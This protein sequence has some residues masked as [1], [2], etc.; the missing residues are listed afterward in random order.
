MD[1]QVPAPGG[2]GPGNPAAL[3]AR[4]PDPA[5]DIP[6]NPAHFFRRIGDLPLSPVPGALAPVPSLLPLSFVGGILGPAV[7]TNG[8]AAVRGF[9]PLQRGV[10]PT[11]YEAVVTQLEAEPQG[12]GLDPTAQYVSVPHAAAAVL[13]AVERIVALGAPLHP[14]YVIGLGDLYDYEPMAPGAP[15]AFIALS[16]APSGLT[17]S[18]LEGPGTFLVHLGF[19]S[20]LCFGICLS[21]SR[22]QPATPTRR[23]LMAVQP[24]AAAAGVAP[25]AVGA[26]I[27]AHDLREWLNLTQPA[28][29]VALIRSF[30]PALQA[31]E[32]NLRDRHHLRFGTVDQKE[33]LVAALATEQPLRAR[34]PNLAR[35]FGLAITSV[36]AVTVL[37]R[38][39]RVAS[40]STSATVVDL[41]ALFRLESMIKESVRSLSSAGAIVAT[42]SDRVSRVEEALTGTQ[43]A[44]GGSASGASSSSSSVYSNDLTTALDNASWRATEA[45]ILAELSQIPPNKL[46]VFELITQSSVLGARQ[47]ALSDKKTA[48]QN[49][50]LSLSDPLRRALDLLSGKGVRHEIVATSLVADLTTRLPSTNEEILFHQVLPFEI[51]GQILRG[52]F[53]EVPW[54]KLLR[55][56]LQVEK[57]GCEIADYPKGLFDPLVPPLLQPRL[58]RLSALLGLP[59]IHVAGTIPVPAAQPANFATLSTIVTNI[60]KGYSAVHGVASPFTDGNHAMLVKFHDASFAEAAQV[61]HRFYGN[62]NPA[63]PVPVSLFNPVSSPA[64]AALSRLSQAMAS[65]SKTAAEQ[66][67]LNGVLAEV[68]AHGGSLASFISSLRSRPPS[69]SSQ[70]AGSPHAASSKAKLEAISPRAA[71]LGARSRSSSPSAREPVGAV[72]SRFHEAVREGA[73]GETFWYIDD[74]GGR[75]SDIYWYAPLEKL[76]GKS[77]HELDFPVILSKRSSAVA[78]ATLSSMPGEKGHTHATDTAFVAPFPDF[79]DQANRLF[80]EPADASGSAVGLIK[81]ER[82]RSRSRSRSRSAERGQRPKSSEADLASRAERGRSPAPKREDGQRPKH[83]QGRKPSKSKSRSRSRSPIQFDDKPAGKDGKGATRHEPAKPDAT[84]GKSNVKGAPSNMAKLFVAGS[85]LVPKADAAATSAVSSWGSLAYTSFAVLFGHARAM[86]MTIAGA[87]RPVLLLG[88]RAPTAV[89]RTFLVIV[90]AIPDQPVRLLA[91]LMANALIG[92]ES[93]EAES[94]DAALT[95]AK[96]LLSVLPLSPFAEEPMLFPSFEIIPTTADEHSTVD[97]IVV[98][99]IHSQRDLPEFTLDG[100]TWLTWMALA[101]ATSA[102]FALV[103]HAVNRAKTFR[104]TISREVFE[105]LLSASTTFRSGARELR[106]APVASEDP[107]PSDAGKTFEQLLG[108]SLAADE[109]LRRTLLSIPDSDPLASQLHAYADRI[110]PADVSEIPPAFK[111]PGVLPTFDSA[112][113]F[114]TPFT[115]RVQPPTTTPLP[116]VLPQ[117]K[118]PANFNP[119]SLRDLLTDEAQRS[120]ERFYGS[121]YDWLLLVD[122]LSVLLERNR[123]AFRAILTQT[124]QQATTRHL[125]R[126]LGQDADAHTKSALALA[127]ALISGSPANARDAWPSLSRAEALHMVRQA[128]V[129][130]YDGPSDDDILARLLAERPQVLAL[131]QSA[132]VPAAR[133]IV[134]DLRGQVPVPLDFTRQITTHLNLDFVRECKRLH[135][136]YPDKELWD[137]LLHGVRFKCGQLTQIVLQPHLSSLPLGFVNVHKELKRLVGKGFFECFENPPFCPWQTLPMGVAFRKLEPDRPRRTTDGGSPRR[138]HRAALITT[139]DGVRYRRDGDSDWLVDSD[140]ARVVPLNV[141]TRWP[142]D[143]I[144]RGT[145]DTFF[146]GWLTRLHSRS[147]SPPPFHPLLQHADGRPLTPPPS[148]PA[149]PRPARKLR[150]FLH[151]FSGEPSEEFTISSYLAALHWEAED[152]D[153]LHDKVEFDVTREES[154]NALLAKV[155]AGKYFIVW[156]GPPCNPYSVADDERPQ[157][158]SVKKPWGVEPCPSE[159]QNYVT[160]ANTVTRFVGRMIVACDESDTHW[161]VENPSPHD[162]PG[163][164]GF[165]EE[166]ADYGTIWHALDSLDDLRL[167]RFFE[168]T[169]PYCAMGMLYQKPTRLRSSL[170]LLILAFSGLVCVHR[171]HAKRLRG[172]VNGVSVTKSAQAYPP[173]MIERAGDAIEAAFVEATSDSAGASALVS[174]SSAALGAGAASQLTVSSIPSPP[175]LRLGTV[176]DVDITRGGPTPHF[177]NPFKMGE[178]GTNRHLREIAV[179]TYRAWLDARVVKAKNWPTSLPVS[180]RLSELTGEIV[181]RHLEG[182]FHRHGRLVRFH[183]VCGARCYGKSC[184]GHAL[185]ALAAQ[186]LDGSSDPPF[187]KE[188]KSTVPEAMSDLAVLLHLSYLTGLPVYQIC[189]DVSDFF[190]QHRLHPSEQPKVGLVTLELDLLVARAGQLRK[191]VPRLCNVAESV[192]GYGLFPA[193][194]VCQRHAY[195]LT[196]LWLVEM[197]MRSRPIVAALCMRFPVLARWRDERQRHLE[198]PPSE[199]DPTERVRLAQTCFWAMS[200][201]SDDSHQKILGC[202]LTV[203]GLRVWIEITSKLNLT[204]AIV[205]KQM[206]GQNVLNQGLRFH[207][208]LGITYVPADKLRRCF[209]SIRLTARGLATLREY[210]SLLGLLQSLLF[211]VGLRRSAMFGLWAPF[212]VSVFSPE[213]PLVPTPLILEK[214]KLWQTRLCEC[215]G[216]SFESGIDKALDS[217]RRATIPPNAKV[218]YVL[219]SDASKMGAVLPGVGGCLGGDGWRYPDD[220]G[221]SEAEL[222]LPIAVTEFAA[223]YGEVESYGDEIPEDACVMAEVDALATVDAV[224]DETAHKELMQLVFSELQE[225][226]QWH[227]IRER[228]VIAHCQGYVNVMADAWSR[229]ELHVAQQLCR[230][231]G[232]AFSQ[233]PSP[234]RLRI[235]MGL[236]LATHAQAKMPI[237][238][239][240][241]DIRFTDGDGPFP[242]VLAQPDFYN[243]AFVAH[244]VDRPC[245]PSPQWS[246]SLFQPAY[247]VLEQLDHQYLGLDF[248]LSTGADVA[249]PSTPPKAPLLQQPAE[250]ASVERAPELTPEA[251]RQRKSGPHPQHLAS[252]VAALLEADTSPLAL[253]P[254]SFTLLS[255]CER[256]YDPR[257]ATAPRTAKGQVS[258]WKHWEAWCALQGTD[259]WRLVLCASTTEH[260]RESILQAGFPAFVEVR[261]SLHPRNGRKAALPSSQAKTLAH[262]RKMH[263]DRGFPMVSSHLV[264]VEIRRLYMKYKAAHGVQD[265]IPKRKQPFT[266]EILLDTMLGAPEGFKMGRYTLR[267]QSRQGR[268]LKALTKT[269]AST[270]FRKAEI[271]V[272]KVGEKCD[273]D[274]LARSSLAWYLRGRHYEA[275]KA[276]AELLRNPR[277]GDFAIL[278]P[279][280][281]KSDPND[282]VWGNSPIW[283]PYT[284]DELSAFPAL[285]EIEL[286]DGTDDPQNTALFTTDAGLPFS[287]SQLDRLL[288][289]FLLR[290]FSESVAHNYSWHSARIW[291]ATALLASNATRAQIQALCRWQTEESLNIYAC[292]GAEQYGQLISGALQVRIDAARAATLAGAVPFIDRTDLQR[293]RA[294]AVNHAAADLD[295]D[296]APDDDADED[297]D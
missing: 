217:Q 130:D 226:P 169:F 270:G 282:M 223:F 266:R 156:M 55:L 16:Q 92:S 221:L 62:N 133:G 90:S 43:A 107:K 252:S 161:I 121:M 4:G 292:L 26:V 50:L 76:S 280:P 32:Q 88:T 262:I 153:I 138:G 215:S 125:L 194:E 231:Q 201:Y 14:A 258:A 173:A 116:P 250:Y 69:R 233:R 12:V 114:S 67:L 278:T 21:G 152:V 272:D 100:P 179:T 160:K 134:W 273:A 216:A 108:Y 7:A 236:L 91:P 249:T 206:I 158:F 165:W 123:R 83:E 239:R 6:A 243:P 172:K 110:S 259:P 1:F 112:E 274:C 271:S 159:W 228:T 203:L 122:E 30:G 58:E 297:D 102:V 33:S 127:Q 87:A 254:T 255:L 183:F 177:A 291:L 166:F 189:T 95:V 124:D 241:A 78:R 86:T 73:D 131:G 207:S 151:I 99:P 141:A 47:L 238:P 199:R 29:N 10:L 146:Q 234:P 72:G 37:Q 101:A 283:L 53:D 155:K 184:H 115:V 137:H 193:S 284:E 219:R 89:V 167:I 230:Q 61:F 195:W 120:V 142:A 296:V 295:Q 128:T 140:G 202:E 9:F 143:D 198:P 263:K 290:H 79:V 293:A 288:K 17:F 188:L 178:S 94:R 59:S 220:T 70:E 71:A 170:R 19:F 97:R 213:E 210:H 247:S 103:A 56:C 105:Q 3:M 24:F 174:S 52:A 261:Q 267:W 229:G 77:R 171:R 68:A 36:S 45:A 74:R 253:R 287:G 240:R 113:L 235:L 135:P 192:L 281:S 246:T 117:R 15:A 42:V 269:L 81:P 98:L 75:R 286:N 149:S 139:R 48:E 256:L 211:V 129:D 209:E 176:I 13:A 222:E 41:A 80:R 191:L 39:Y 25:V 118:P 168:V 200:M 23:F 245:S 242:V 264:Q 150:R 181:A 224:V 197:L 190:N 60:A 289:Y 44:S 148:R 232:M 20:F 185:V 144:E 65:Q 147:G 214:L 244:A 204:M 49:R 186:L 11:K 85:S 51:S 205:Q 275:T 84:P 109:H 227:A 82:E 40:R 212:A 251:K 265:L 208:G 248:S 154:S 8:Q 164:L 104:A 93:S 196:F 57:R 27:A 106:F 119:T 237:E 268:S 35:V 180:R 285:A 163:V 111:R 218:V 22:D 63:G 157:L 18:M 2:V 5:I 54:I 294:D 136:T 132:L 182:L 38:L 277:S 46:I 126:L 64:I 279:G 276:P 66:P 31:R 162:V 96:Q 187:P 175:A 34:L 225:L 260:H 28:E 145:L 257:D